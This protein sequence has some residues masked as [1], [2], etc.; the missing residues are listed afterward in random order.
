MV[1]SAHPARAVESD[2]HRAGGD[3]RHSSELA[4][5]LRHLCE[6]VQLYAGRGVRRLHPWLLRYRGLRRYNDS[7]LRNGMVLPAVHR[8]HSVVWLAIH[9]RCG[10]W[11]YL[12]HRHRMELRLRLRIWLLPVVLPVVGAD[13][14]LRMGLVSVLR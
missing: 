1:Q 10:S 14:L 6:G 7:S 8:S 3:L 9:L 12:H 2:G 5:L 11:I 4:A 13:G